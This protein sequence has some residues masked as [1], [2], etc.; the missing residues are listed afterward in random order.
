MTNKVLIT[1]A[2][3]GIGFETARQLAHQGWY[4]LLGVR[5]RQRGEAAIDKLKQENITSVELVDIDLNDLSSIQSAAEYVKTH[6]PDLSAV[7]NNAGIPG[8][9]QKRPLDFEVDEL[10]S[11]IDVNFYGNFAM[12]KA[13]APILAS[14]K[15]K[16]LNLTIPSIGFSTFRPF[17]Y[18]A[19][20]APLNSMIKSI[21]YD[22][23]RNNVPVEVYG[24]MPGGVQTD[25]NGHMDGWMMHTLPEG[26]K[27]VAEA[28]LDKHNHQGK[29][30]NRMGLSSLIKKNILRKLNLSK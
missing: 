27:T 10:R 8:D 17:A 5:N 2:N 29:I 20:K 28:L 9:M 1:G 15:G 26:G 22:F 13:F 24:V 19:S 21:G 18:M 16:I 4:V 6:H 7:I 25:L 30:L 14:N 3:K 11:V 12:I 23:K